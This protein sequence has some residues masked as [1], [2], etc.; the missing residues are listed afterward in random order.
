MPES[1]DWRKRGATS[2]VKN[3]G[4]C[5]SCWA[6]ATGNAKDNENWGQNTTINSFLQL[7]TLNLTYKSTLKKQLKNS[8]LN[9][10]FPAHQMY[11][12]V[13][14]KVCTYYL[15]ISRKIFWRNIVINKNLS[16]GCQGSIPELGFTYTQLFGLV[17]EADY[18]Y[19]SKYVQ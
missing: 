19:V 15:L 4:I 16:G 1:V 17:S 10:L 7:K 11:F 9:R 13:A 3:Q 14:E 2:A 18:P 5:G 6:F 12:N 8:R